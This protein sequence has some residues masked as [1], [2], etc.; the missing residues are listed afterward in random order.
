M[1]LKQAI[2]TRNPCYGANVNKQDE[3]YVTFQRL[4]PRGLMLHSVGCPQPSAQVFVDLWDKP[5]YTA[6]CVHGFIDAN[7]GTIYQTLPWYFRGWHGG[8]GN[9]GNS[10]DTHVGVEMCEPAQIKYTSGC[11]FT[12]SDFATA[13]AAARRTYNAAVELFAMLCKKYN[14]DPLK[15]GVIVS[16]A[17]GHSLGIATNHGDP[18]HLWRGLGMDL[19]MDGFRKDV[20][21]TIHQNESEEEDMQRFQTVGEL[22][23]PY[24]ADIQKL[25]D[26]GYLKG[27]GDINHLDLTEDTA[28]VLII[29]GRMQG[30]L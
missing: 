3:R 4:G 8:Y 22:P 25:I 30:V 6:A 14:L 20:Y 17:E 9:K 29:C 2:L 13:R 24:R 7:T 21:N 12:C 18:E 11:T 28:R 27:K 23:E 26:K 15:P 16:H 5:E 10:N 19:S 1:N